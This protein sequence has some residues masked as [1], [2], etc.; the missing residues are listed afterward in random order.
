[1]TYR[2]LVKQI[3]EEIKIGA[4]L[5]YEEEYTAKNII[6]IVNQNREHL[7]YDNST[8]KYNWEEEEHNVNQS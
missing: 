8:H 4:E 6:G 7:D 1:M 2:D 3:A 5:G